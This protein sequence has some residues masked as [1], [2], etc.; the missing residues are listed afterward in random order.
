MPI[1]QDHCRSGWTAAYALIQNGRERQACSKTSPQHGA[2]RITEAVSTS[3]CPFPIA[4]RLPGGLFG[5]EQG[6]L[7]PDPAGTAG[8]QRLSLKGP[9]AISSVNHRMIAT[10]Y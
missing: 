8:Q 4:G 6:S 7:R 1:R 10:N 5:S 2:V 9:H 3:Q